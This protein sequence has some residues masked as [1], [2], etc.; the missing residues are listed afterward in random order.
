MCYSKVKKK[1]NLPNTPLP[2]TPLWSSQIG[3]TSPQVSME[4]HQ[5]LHQPAWPVMFANFSHIS[6]SSKWKQGYFSAGAI[7]KNK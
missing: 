4:I 2:G 1:N 6:S 3:L 7:E 5:I